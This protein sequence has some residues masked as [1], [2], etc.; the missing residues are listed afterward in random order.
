[1]SVTEFNPDKWLETLHRGIH[2]FVKD[3]V[4]SYVKNDLDAPAG[5][6]AYDIVMD[7]PEAD[8]PA[9]DIRLEKTLI[10]FVVDDIDS[11]KLGF[12][13]DIVNAIEELH[14]A[15]DPD[16]VNF[17]QAR[18]HI[19]NYD[20]GIWASDESGGSTSRLVTYQMLDKIFGGDDAR[21][22][23]KDATKG[24]EILAFSGGT[25]ITERVNDVRVFRVIDCELSVRVFS[26]IMLADEV[27]VEDIVQNP[28]LT[29]DGN[30]I[31]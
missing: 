23:F 24:I 26:R 2:D 7:W 13:Q 10:H 18:R 4:N 21:R 17:H 16:I 22:D 3:R 15:P 6:S 25:F 30:L 9:R 11:A 8:D 29:I 27:I 31:S 1:M 20:V 28:S 12:G 14:D 19:V 5:L